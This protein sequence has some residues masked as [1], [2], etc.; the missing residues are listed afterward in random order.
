MTVIETIRS[1]RSI[2]HFKSDPV[3]AESVL[4]IFE[5]AV[6]APNHGRTEPWRFTILGEQTK[7]KVAEQYREL[8]LKKMPVD[9]SDDHK[10]KAGDAAFRK[11]IEKPTIAA[12][13]CIQDGDEIR[14]RED[15]AATCCAM[16]NV[17]LAAWEEGI[18]M[19]WSTGQITREHSTYA[20]LDI[21]PAGEYIIGFFYLGY[22]A[23][24]PQSKRRPLQ[25][26]LRLT[27]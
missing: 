14:R 25:D 3:P 23:K 9:A 15:Y 11:M 18:G 22:P 5:A 24:I 17:Q 6:W 8:A 21:D 20:M 13:S 16:Q 27:P 26:F 4:K 7:L 10:K 12:V 2:F 1:R 19:Q